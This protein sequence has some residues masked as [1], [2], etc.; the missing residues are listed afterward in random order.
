LDS[1]IRFGFGEPLIKATSGHFEQ[2]AHGGGAKDIAMIM[3]KALLHS[4]FLTNSRIE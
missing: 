4:G 2:A 3:D 1:A